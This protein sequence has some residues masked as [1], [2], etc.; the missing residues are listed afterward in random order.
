[1]STVGQVIHCRAAVAWE[2]KAPLVIETIE[3]DPPKAG[4][5]RIKVGQP[6]ILFD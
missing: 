4:E 2:P 3:V 1:M 5:V 6:C